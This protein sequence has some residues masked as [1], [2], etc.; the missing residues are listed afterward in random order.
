MKELF[1][2][3]G[4]AVTLFV[5]ALLLSLI[6]NLSTATGEIHHCLIHGDV[7]TA[8]SSTYPIAPKKYWR[9]EGVR[10]WRSNVWMGVADTIDEAIEIATK[11]NC[12]VG[13]ESK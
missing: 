8:T 7:A 13:P 2:I 4:A 1:G 5:V 12:R 10:Y 6:I 11:A 9:V 3:A